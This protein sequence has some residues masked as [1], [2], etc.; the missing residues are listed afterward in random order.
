MGGV[1]S[2]SR[3]NKTLYISGLRRVPNLEDQITTHFC[4]WG[5][6]SYVK[7]IYDKA[8]AFVR[9]K[10]RCSAEFAK[11]AMQ[12]QNL[13]GDEVL[14]IR[15]SN[16]DPNP[17][18]KERDDAELYMQIA[19]KIA[20]KRAREEPQ[21]EYKQL[22]SGQDGEEALV[23]SFPSQY[24][25]N[26]YPDTTKQYAQYDT[27]QPVAEW[28]QNLGLSKYMNNFVSA[29]YSDLAAVSQLDEYGL[30]TVGIIDLDNRV[31][32]LSAAE[33][34]RATYFPTYQDVNAYYQYG[35]QA[36]YVYANTEYNPDT[37]RQQQYYNQYY[38]QQAP[39]QAK[40]AKKTK[41]KPAGP[42]TKAQSLVAY[43]D[44]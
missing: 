3:D 35:G 27:T 14:S 15:W 12:D 41:P 18:A 38:Q 8:I 5:E 11:E 37:E 22:S 31:K 16:E 6:L 2:F 9:Y 43:E 40:P 20:E 36:Q 1:G 4:E 17:E 39:N 10:L 42:P 32:L 28:L 23:D 26:Q 24:D 7:V 34:L 19:Q 13:D 44:E 33:E 25:A 29:G 21:Y 30:D